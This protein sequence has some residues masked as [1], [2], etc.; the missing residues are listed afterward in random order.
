[1]N[2]RSLTRV[3]ISVGFLFMI[4]ACGVLNAEE[5]APP[6]K[7]TKAEEPAKEPAAHKETR[8]APAEK[9]SAETV[10]GEYEELLDELI[11]VVAKYERDRIAASEQRIVALKE[12]LKKRLQSLETKH[13]SRQTAYNK[14]MAE[15]RAE[16]L[17]TI[18]IWQW[19]AEAGAELGF[20]AIEQALFVIKLVLQ[21]SSIERFAAALIVRLIMHTGLGAGI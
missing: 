14:T 15:F 12:E 9:R 5:K 13:E 18:A 11:E 10:D 17:A 1:M 6:A 2:A 20:H 7:A 3:G 19:A 8:T 4:A 16:L 21:S